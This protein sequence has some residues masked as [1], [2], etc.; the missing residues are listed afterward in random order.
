MLSKF[1]LKTNNE[2]IILEIRC[3]TDGSENGKL[4]APV[5]VGCE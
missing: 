2:H 4:V 3:L 5:L 1:K